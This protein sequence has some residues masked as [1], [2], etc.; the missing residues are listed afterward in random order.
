MVNSDPEYIEDPYIPKLPEFSTPSLDEFHYDE[1]YIA[2]YE[3]AQPTFDSSGNVE[4]PPE[5]EFYLRT[6]TLDQIFSIDEDED[7]LQPSASRASAR[8]S[9]VLTKSEKLK[10]LFSKKTMRDAK[11]S[12]IDLSKPFVAKISNKENYKKFLRFTGNKSSG[13]VLRDCEVFC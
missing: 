6:L 8:K 12:I 7:G 5:T 10:L 3:C 1:D 2:Q 11:V 13:R 9:G 4:W